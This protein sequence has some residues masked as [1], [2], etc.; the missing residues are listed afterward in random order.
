M[1]PPFLDNNPP[2]ATTTS[3]TSSGK[4]VQV[5][6]QENENLQRENQLLQQQVMYWKGKF[7]SMESMVQTLLST[8]QRQEVNASQPS[9]IQPSPLSLPQQTSQEVA[10]NQ[11]L[12]EEKQNNAAMDD[13]LIQSYLLEYESQLQ[14]LRISTKKISSQV[15]QIG[16]HIYRIQSS[17]GKLLCTPLRTTT[18]SNQVAAAAVEFPQLLQQLQQLHG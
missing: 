2:A 6:I 9:T 3:N 17:K 12:L 5:L 15:Y 7:E 18:S 16:Q 8:A 14:A 11:A 4:W 10:L 13:F 1:N